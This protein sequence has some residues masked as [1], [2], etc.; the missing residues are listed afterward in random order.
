MG[1]PPGV[2]QGTNYFRPA[3]KPTVVV[4]TGAVD[5]QVM[6]RLNQLENGMGGYVSYAL[7]FPQRE[8]A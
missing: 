2:L 1:G 7:T 3:G 5:T 4:V 6:D 8:S